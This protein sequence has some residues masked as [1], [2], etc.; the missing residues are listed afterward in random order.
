VATGPQEEEEAAA[1]TTA[2]SQVL[3]PLTPSQGRGQARPKS[4]RAGDRE[5]VGDAADDDA[6][7]GWG[8]WG[9]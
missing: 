1:T 8:K 9:S 6:P 4:R 3:V 5:A 2:T 7:P